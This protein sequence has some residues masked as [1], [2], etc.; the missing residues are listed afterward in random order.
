MKT[1]IDPMQI[2]RYD[3]PSVWPEAEPFL[4]EALDR[5]IGDY[6]IEDL[7]SALLV[8]EAALLAFLDET[9]DMIGA[10]VTQMLTHPDGRSICKILAFGAK[11]FERV[12]HAI[13]Q[14]AYGAKLR[15]AQAIVFHGRPGW[16]RMLKGDGFTVSQVIMERLL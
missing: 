11:D 14:V 8:G 7:H 9:G 2:D 13:D 6:S 1:I 4:R 16:E 3:V 10:G 15:G 12:H 5:G